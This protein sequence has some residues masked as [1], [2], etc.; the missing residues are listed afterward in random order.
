[1]ATE[2]LKFPPLPREAHFIL[3]PASA[4]MGKLVAPLGAPMLS[5]GGVIELADRVKFIISFILVA[6]IAV[7]IRYSS[8]KSAPAAASPTPSTPGGPASSSAASSSLLPGPSTQKAISSTHALLNFPERGEQHI[9]EDFGNLRNHYEILSHQLFHSDMPRDVCKQS[10]RTF[11]QHLNDFE[12][13]YSPSRRNPNFRE[14]FENSQRI[15]N[16]FSWIK[17][18]VR[19]ITRVPARGD[20]LFE[21]VYWCLLNSTK[22]D[23][24][25]DM[26]IGSHEGLRQVVVQWLQHHLDNPELRAQ[27]DASINK[28]IQD[29][30]EFDVENL[31]ST[32]ATLNQDGNVTDAQ[33]KRQ[34]LAELQRYLDRFKE[35]GRYDLYLEEM[36]KPGFFAGDVEIYAVA[37]I[38]EIGIDIEPEYED[39]IV[40]ECTIRFNPEAVIRMKLVSRAA[41]FDYKGVI[42]QSSSS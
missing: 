23:R 8:L 2:G 25:R 26:E 31:K 10:L 6:L 33:G 32:I 13:L 16:N 17:D 35:P 1:M 27:I 22:R 21:S 3:G 19:G 11:A 24:L 34:E 40:K 37:Q 12:N 4:W 7:A 42:Q 30:T 28:F 14:I 29:R 15:K 36:K 5:R 41:H 39:R 38:F 18:I 20:C 9:G